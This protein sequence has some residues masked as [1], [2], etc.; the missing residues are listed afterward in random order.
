MSTHVTIVGG[1]LTGLVSAITAAES[2]A[3]VRLFEAHGSLGGRARSTE[4]PY[5][6][7]LGAHAVYTD[8][9][10]WAFCTERGILPPVVPP[11]LTGA[12]FLHRGQVRS[13]PPLALLRAPLLRLRAPAEPSFREWAGSRWGEPTA[14]VLSAAA[15]V[16]SFH[17]DP[18]ALSAA[19]VA[20]RLARVYAVPPRVRFIRSG[21]STLVDS[22]AAHARALGVQIETN[23]RVDRLPEPPVVIA[24]DLRTAARL[25]D[26]DTLSATGTTAVLLDL[27]LRRRR[28]DPYLVADLDG[29]GWVERFSTKDPTLCPPGEE[30]LQA[31]TGL[32]PHESTQQALDRLHRV[33]DRSHPGWQRRRTWVRTARVTDLTGALDLPGRTWRDR[34]GIDR[35]DGVYLAGDMVAAPGLLAE[36]AVTSAVQAG[37]S[38]TRAL[39]PHIVSQQSLHHGRTTSG[40]PRG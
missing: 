38:A 21:W 35:G 19:F 6:A 34:P 27:A 9:S 23:A 8:G 39:Q 25:L 14:A 15:G 18:G 32:R 28:G 11:P 1:G 37:R 20:E 22:L 30:L 3:P 13:R 4:P 40:S 12:R 7:N 2:G 16:F 26:D 36:V 24:T 29:A 31:H 5:V 33:L 17:Y 10:I